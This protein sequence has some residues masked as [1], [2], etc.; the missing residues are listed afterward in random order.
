MPG[1]PRAASRKLTASQVGLCLSFFGVCKSCRKL[2]RPAAWGRLPNVAFS[3]SCPQFGRFE[4]D[5][6]LK[7]LQGRQ[8]E[9]GKPPCGSS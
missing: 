9:L 8:P 4:V 6:L 7:L 2:F 1:G 3:E 5:A